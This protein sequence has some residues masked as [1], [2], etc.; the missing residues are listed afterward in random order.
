MIG[1]EGMLKLEIP[2]NELFDEATGMF[3]STKSTVLQLEHSLI[4]LA[5]WESKWHKPF[6][7]DKHEKTDEELRDYI[8]C[9]TIT[10]NVDPNVYSALSIS[11]IEKIK[12][13]MENPMTAT[14]FNDKKMPKSKQRVTT[15]ELIYYWMISLQIPFECER[16][17]INRLLT[18]IRV[19]NIENAPKE[20]MKKGDI[21]RQNAELNAA[22]M[23]ARA[24]KR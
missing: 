22:R 19:C 4:S 17:H 24:K 7:D 12:E 1:D 21:Y 9:M 3:I 8:R 15:A 20:K 2:E 23:A 11:D 6:M 16:W 10:Q 13:Y 14:W 5:K 18:L